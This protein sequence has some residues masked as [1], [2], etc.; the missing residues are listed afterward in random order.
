ML[1]F[2]H[3][4]Q[5]RPCSASDFDYSAH[6]SCR[7]QSPVCHTRVSCPAQAIRRIS[8]PFERYICGI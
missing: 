4:R 1:R 3:F 2:F 7:G 5:N 6:F 8:M